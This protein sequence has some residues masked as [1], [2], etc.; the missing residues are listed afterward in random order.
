MT[1]HDL[2]NLN[3]G[4][5]PKYMKGDQGS[6]GRSMKSEYDYGSKRKFVD[7]LGNV[8]KK[9]ALTFEKLDGQKNDTQSMRSK[10]SNTSS[11]HRKNMSM[12]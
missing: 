6:D 7:V 9:N 3:R 5:D 11:Y 2:D 12:T 8:N 10:Y 1:R 4:S